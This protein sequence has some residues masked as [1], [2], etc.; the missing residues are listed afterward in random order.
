MI[1]HTLK[2][3]LNYPVPKKIETL[4]L[5]KDPVKARNL[6]AMLPEWHG[7]LPVI[8]VLFTYLFKR[9]NSMRKH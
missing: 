2:Q 8:R 5:K 7:V 3:E 1:I 9:F 6:E 4:R